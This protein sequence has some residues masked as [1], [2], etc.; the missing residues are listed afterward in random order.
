MKKD[1]KIL[2]INPGSTSTKIGVFKNEEKI[3][4]TTVRHSSKMLDQ[5]AKIWD[6]YS[7][8]KE[9]IIKSEFQDLPEK[10]SGVLA[11]RI[12]NAR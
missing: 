12:E 3:F 11:Q 4:E 1:Y 9:E 5:Y 8:R 10:P 7:F 2:T 6:Q